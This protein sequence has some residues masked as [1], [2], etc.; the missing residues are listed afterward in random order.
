M[1]AEN[2]SIKSGSLSMQNLKDERKIIA[3]N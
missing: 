2:A 1:S 3:L